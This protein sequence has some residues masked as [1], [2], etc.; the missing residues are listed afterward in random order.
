MLRGNLQTL[1]AVGV[2]LLGSRKWY[3]LFYDK[4][5]KETYEQN[6]KRDHCRWLIPPSCSPC[7][8]LT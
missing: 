4:F 5:E 7:N 6:K 1:Y 2:C 8:H 3:H